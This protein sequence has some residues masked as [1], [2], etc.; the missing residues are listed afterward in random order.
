[1]RPIAAVLLLL[2]VCACGVSEQDRPEPVEVPAAPPARAGSA[3]ANGGAEV[4]VFFIR[5]AR[6][7]EVPRSAPRSDIPTAL[8][9]L[10]GGP[11][12][13][14][15]L[16]GLRTA[17][18]PQPLEPR[19]AAP[20]SQVVTV[21]VTR[22]FTDVAGGNQLRAVAQVVWTAT[23]FPE[24]QLVRF[25]AEGEELEVPTDQGLTDRP[26]SRSD[27]GSVA[28]RRSTPSTSQPAPSTTTEADAPPAEGP[29]AV[30]PGDEMAP[31]SPTDAVGSTPSTG[32]PD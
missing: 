11:T 10:V 31:G 5:G 3:S 22:D 4:A 26:V 23:Q 32:P 6:L 15:V 21:D 16:G 14:E 25:T 1:M 27:Y 2:V 28:P 13:A 24:V 8:D 19:V 29:T 20:L 9:L 18:A 30:E 12:R 7:E 17:L